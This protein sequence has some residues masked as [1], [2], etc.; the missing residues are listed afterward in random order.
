MVWYGMV[1][2][3]EHVESEY[4]LDMVSCM[5]GLEKLFLVVEFEF[6]SFSKLQITVRVIRRTASSVYGMVWYGMVWYGM[7]N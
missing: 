6:C 5:K 7:S 1:W 4:A 2:Y 3:S